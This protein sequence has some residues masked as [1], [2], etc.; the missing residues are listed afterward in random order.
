VGH[1]AVDDVHVVAAEQAAK[2]LVDVWDPIFPRKL[3]SVR[4]RIRSTDQAVVRGAIGW[5]VLGAH[6]ACI[7]N[8]PDPV[9]KV[10]RF[11]RRSVRRPG[12]VV[13]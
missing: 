6:D 12:E 7:A 9:V 1:S 3:K 11:E 4:V 10:V 5:Q 2:V 13:A 8:D